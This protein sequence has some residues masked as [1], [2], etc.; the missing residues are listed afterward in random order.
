MNITSKLA[1]TEN[2]IL[3]SYLNISQFISLNIVLH[4]SLSND[5]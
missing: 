1:L 2:G 5:I 3:L 4:L